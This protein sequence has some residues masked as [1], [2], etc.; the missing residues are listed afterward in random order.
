MRKVA[1]LLKHGDIGRLVLFKTNH[2]AAALV[3]ELRES[4]GER[5]RERGRLMLINFVGDIAER[6]QG[7]RIERV[8]A[9]W[10][11]KIEI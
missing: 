1:W 6:T 9:S 2:G 4:V 3:K 11:T 7:R 5:Y 10:Y 8:P